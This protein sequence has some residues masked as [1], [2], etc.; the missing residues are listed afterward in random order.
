MKNKFYLL[1]FGLLTGMTLFL[2]CT[3]KGDV[4]K[5]VKI[6]DKNLTS[7]RSGA[8]CEYLFTEQA[9]LKVDNSFKTGTY[10]LFWFKEQSPGISTSVY[11]K[12][13]MQGNS[14]E[15]TKADLLA[16][17]VQFSQL[18]PACYLISFKPV[19]GYVKGVNTTPEKPADQARW[20]LEGKVILQ[21]TADPSIKDT[22]FVKQY[23]S[24]NFIFN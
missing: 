17:R 19:D 6:D 3:K 5:E 8:G 14:F 23:F 11:I 20:L 10:R 7:C 16:N 9:D 1:L 18:C 13:P 2:S 12:A 4:Q 22:V 24:P 15:L 21:G